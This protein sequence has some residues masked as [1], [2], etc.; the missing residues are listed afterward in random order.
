MYYKETMK[1]SLL[2]VG[3]LCSLIFISL[4]AGFYFSKTIEGVDKTVFA[5]NDVSVQ[6][7]ASADQLAGP[8]E[9]GLATVKD[10][11]GNLI[12]LP[13]FKAQPDITYYQPG[14]FIYGASSFVPTYEDSVYLSR[15]SGGSYLDSKFSSPITNAPYIQGGICTNF[16]NDPNKLEQACNVV[17][18]NTCASTSCCI[19]L[20]GS[21]CVS[22][23]EKGPTMKSN[24]SDIGVKNRDYY[25]FQGQCY[26][27]CP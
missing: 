20:G 23:D 9:T 3:I 7:H 4:V 17:D 11:S 14:T 22:G 19:L 16:K 2:K 1:L 24:Y 18:A 27:N 12:N 15:T 5:A 21:K 6:Y 26:G 25:Y 10:P 8:S 13:S